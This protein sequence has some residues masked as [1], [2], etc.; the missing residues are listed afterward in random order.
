MLKIQAI[1]FLG[2]DVEKKTNNNGGYFYTGSLGVR[3][4]KEVT[5]WIKI[6]LDGERFNKVA[7]HLK[8]GKPIFAEGKAK[9]STY[10]AKDGTTKVDININ[11]SDIQ[12]ISTGNREGQDVKVESAV[13]QSATEQIPF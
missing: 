6:L 4:S 1:G 10:I 9:V 12:F 5:T 2:A 7:P 8:K 13:Q 3:E 11:V